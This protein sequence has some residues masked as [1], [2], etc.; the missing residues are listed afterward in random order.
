MKHSSLFVLFLTAA[1]LFLIGLFIHPDHSL[2]KN[3]FL[4]TGL[5][6]ASIFYVNTIRHAVK[7][8]SSSVTR[9]TFWIAIMICLP[10][11]GNLFYVISDMVALRRTKQAWQEAYND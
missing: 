5:L 3:I 7:V 1:W 9:R 11:I 4:A 10:F 6:P 2:F 8:S